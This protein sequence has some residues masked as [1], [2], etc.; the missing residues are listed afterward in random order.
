M[1]RGTKGQGFSQSE[2]VI[3]SRTPLT[4]NKNYQ[5]NPFWKSQPSYNHNN[6][7]QKCIKP[8]AR[9]NP[10]FPIPIRCSMFDVSPDLCV[11]VPLWQNHFGNRQIKP[12]Q[13]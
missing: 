1:K 7:Q 8:A 12:N 2:D 6:L 10:F 11:S 3:R 5:T 4:K 13:T 9:T